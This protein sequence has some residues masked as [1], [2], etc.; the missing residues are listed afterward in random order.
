[1]INLI[2]NTFSVSTKYRSI[3]LQTQEKDLVDW[4]Y[5]LDPLLAGTI[6]YIHVYMINV[7]VAQNFHK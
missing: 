6:R 1:M 2:Q 5:A 4:L 7:F 3:V